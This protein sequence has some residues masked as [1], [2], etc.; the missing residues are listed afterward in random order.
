MPND[1]TL[2][3]L[4][5]DDVEQL[6]TIDDVLSATHRAFVLHAEGQGRVFPVVREKLAT[7]GVF[8]IKSGDVQA[9]AL[10]GFKAAGFWPS[11]RT[12]GGE[13]HQATVMLV[14]PATG[15]PECVIDG[16]AITTMRTGAAGG[17]G[18]RNLARKDSESLCVFGKGTQAR[19]QVT[20]ALHLMQQLKTVRYVTANGEPDAAF[21]ALFAARCAV[22]HAK[23]ADEAVAQSDIVITATPGGGPLF[24]AD[25][26]RPGTHIN[27]VGADTKGKRELPP[28]MLERAQVYVDDRV[29]ASQIGELQWSPDTPCVELGS[30]LGG[31]ASV[32]R[33]DEAITIFDMTG[34]ALQDLTVSRML[35]DRAR[36]A[37]IGTNVAWPW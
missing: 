15:R 18:L 6:L 19:I 7:G 5:K 8:G 16:N 4:N 17:L 3:L 10:L 22:G 32:G 2:L 28:G 36:E 11:N 13:P 25:A 33:L 31:A 30:V 29:Q 26:V 35:R 20:F 27:C 23:Q 1:A 9:E 14:D 21:E 37:G 34:L 24:S 12:L